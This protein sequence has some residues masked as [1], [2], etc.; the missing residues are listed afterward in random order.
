MVQ[1]ETFQMHRNHQLEAQRDLN[2]CLQKEFQREAYQLQMNARM[3]AERMQREAQKFRRS[4]QMSAN[5]YKREVQRVLRDMPMDTQQN[6]REVQC[7]RKRQPQLHSQQANPDILSITTAN[8]T[9]REE[10]VLDEVSPYCI[11]ICFLTFI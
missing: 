11:E 9:P 4:V 8:E 2:Q 5:V 7:F 3:E 1:T 6:Q 10:R